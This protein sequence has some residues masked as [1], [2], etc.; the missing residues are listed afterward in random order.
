MATVVRVGT[1]GGVVS[2]PPLLVLV[3]RSDSDTSAAGDIAVDS[4]TKM[5]FQAYAA[6]DA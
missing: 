5:A 1:L 6:A 2:L 3:T 4:L